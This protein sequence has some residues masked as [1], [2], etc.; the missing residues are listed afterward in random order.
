[1]PINYKQ[2]H[3]AWKQISRSIIRDRA[4]N[5]CELCNAENYKPHWKTG[6]RVILTVHHIYCDKSNNIPLNLIALCQRCHLRLDL[7]IRIKHRKQK[8]EAQ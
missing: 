6:S 8:S 3:P 1:M 2:Y 4:K 5:H 7:P